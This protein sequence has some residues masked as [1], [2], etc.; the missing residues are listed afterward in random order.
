M[1]NAS[2]LFQSELAPP[3]SRGKVRDVYAIG[4]DRVLLV[5]SDRVSA[6]DVVLPTPIP[7]KG[8]LLTQIAGFRLR[9]I[10]GRGLCNS[11]LISTSAAAI[12]D[13]L[14]E[15]ASTTRESLKGRITLGSRC[16]VLP[17]ECVVRG[18]LEGTGWAEYQ[19]RGSVSGVALPS[20]LE[21]CSKL[22]EP[23]F[24]PATKAAQGDHDENIDARTA[25][26]L[27]GAAAL[28][29]VREL[30]LAIYTQAAAYAIE[31]GIIIADTKFEFGY[32][33]DTG[34][35]VIV[36]EALTPDSS[37]FWPAA[38]YEPG[39]PQPSFDKQFIREYLGDLVKRGEWDKTDPGPDLPEYVVEGTISRYQEAR[40]RLLR[41]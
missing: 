12:P 31:R 27:I 36:D 18:F 40:D 39:R 33:V 34:E 20:G 13:A 41:E 28:E 19:E 5:A 7:G 4:D 29:R 6:F 30:S 32:R 2:T 8:R 21:R 17:I 14:F 3:V 16:D 22:P 24:T 15:G 37:R 25:A 10:E 38:S 23:I 9:V 1:G 26:S 11:F 35:L